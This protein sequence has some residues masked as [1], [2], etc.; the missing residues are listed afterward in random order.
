MSDPMPAFRPPFRPLVGLLMAATVTAIAAYLLYVGLSPH[1][2]EP[3][4]KSEAEAAAAYLR[5]REVV[6]L[7]GPLKTI[8]ADTKKP[9]VP[10]EKH[11]LLGHP[12]PAFHLSDVDDHPVSLDALLAKG[13]VVL[14]FYYGYTCNHCVAQLFGL[15]DDLKYVRELG[16]TAVAVSPDTAAQTREKYAKY[17]AFGFPVLS[18]PD[19]AIASRYGVYRPKIGAA[20]DWEA[21]G[22]F[23][24]D[25]GGVVRWANTGAE[26]FTDTVTLLAELDRLNAT[27]GE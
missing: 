7:S 9:R 11:P 2:T 25:R 20:P 23:V 24:I 13:P 8:L 1:P 26:P 10:T 22:T 5:E 3:A 21:H 4:E 19:R 16:A 12:A 6:P 14:V 18:D 17:G 15:N 27:K